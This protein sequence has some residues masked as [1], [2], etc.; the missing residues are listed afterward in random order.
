MIIIYLKIIYNIF[1][2]LQI[3][4]NTYRVVRNINQSEDSSILLEFYRWLCAIVK[5]WWPILEK[6]LKIA[7]A[8]WLLEWS[9]CEKLCLVRKINQYAS[10]LVPSDNRNTR[11]TCPTSDFTGIGQMLMSRPVKQSLLSFASILIYLSD[12]T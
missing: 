6:S 3:S 9:S 12:E 7:G 5:R 11:S 10:A 8:L 1:Y 2:M 4:K